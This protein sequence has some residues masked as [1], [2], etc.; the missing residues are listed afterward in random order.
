MMKIRARRQP[1]EAEIIIIPMIDT[2]MF[3]L[4]F[5]I[6]ASLALAVQNGL[7]VN[8]PKASTGVQHSAQNVTL[9][10]DSAGNLHL[11]TKAINVAD[12]TSELKTLGVTDST[13]V[14]INADGRVTHGLVTT[15][16][17]NARKAG[18]ERF[19]IATQ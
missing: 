13:L 6:V 5:F 15:V 14:I 18:V 11:N 17:D 9:T 19:A 10:L 3:L 7:P 1:E 8:L 4:M 12:E 16:M 2:M